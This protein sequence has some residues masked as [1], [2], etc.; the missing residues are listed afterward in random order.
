M[1]FIVVLA[2]GIFPFHAFAKETS[3]KV[4]NIVSVTTA[5]ASCA[6]PVGLWVN[7]MGSKLKIKAVDAT[8]GAVSG[9][10]QTKTGAGGWFPLNGWV[11]SLPPNSAKD[12]AK[13]ISFSVRWG[14][15][16]S[17][18]SWSGFC[19]GTAEFRTV[20]NLGRPITDFEWDHI[21]TGADNFAPQ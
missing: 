4:E 11:N 2:I 19:R 15:V 16:G 17:I 12:N 9:E 14:S 10:Y 21:L 13:I 18:T 3:P 8:T 20:W 6:N 5:K 7:Q 1:K